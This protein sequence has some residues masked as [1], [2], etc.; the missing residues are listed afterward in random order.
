MQSYSYQV[1]Y[2]S[3]TVMYAYYWSKMELIEV[4]Q[5]FVI[6]C[7]FARDTMINT[8]LLENIFGSL[9]KQHTKA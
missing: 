9:L 8:D 2:T 7:M 4:T 6:V 3:Y 5:N 1:K